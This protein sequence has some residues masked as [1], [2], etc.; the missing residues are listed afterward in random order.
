MIKHFI[1]R[2]GRA[3]TA[4]KGRPERPVSMEQSRFDAYEAVDD[5]A[6]A[7]TFGRVNI[8][9]ALLHYQKPDVNAK[10][11]LFDG[12]TPLVSA[13]LGNHAEIVGILAGAGADVNAKVDGGVTILMRVASLGYVETVEALLECGADVNA[14]DDHGSTPLM[15]GVMSY[16]I[17]VMKALLDAGADVHA[18]DSKGAT[19]S[20]MALNVRPRRF[21]I[22]R[23]GDF[24]FTW[25]DPNNE[26]FRLLKKAEGQTHHLV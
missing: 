16:S 11:G 1:D 10:S 2:L 25:E 13:S 20:I 9:K 19:A 6:F 8:V 23:S 5:L 3:Y 21:E 24:S 12:T 22:G 14:R 7:S 18:K 4:Y 17:D 15:W 26:I